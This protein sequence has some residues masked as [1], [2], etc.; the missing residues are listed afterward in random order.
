M[1]KSKTLKFFQFAW[2]VLI[3]IWMASCDDSFS[4]IGSDIVGGVNFDVDTTIV[5]VKATNFNL[6]PI[7]TSNLPSQ[8]LGVYNDPVFGQTRANMVA[9]LVLQQFNPTFGDNPK[10]KNVVLNL[11][12]FS[13]RL[14]VLP[15]GE[16]IYRLD[17]IFGNEPFKL[18]IY[19][20]GFFLN[21]LDPNGNFQSVIPV[22]SDQDQQ[23]FNNRR[24]LLYE[25][26]TV[27]INKNEIVVFPDTGDPAVDT[28][29]S[30]RLPPAIRLE[31]NK[32]FFKRKILDNE[33]K[34]E[35]SNINNFQNFI[36]G[37]YFV[38]EPLSDNKNGMV[39]LDLNQAS[40][41]MN[42][43]FEREVTRTDSLG[44]SVQ[45]ID[46]VDASLAFRFTG[47]KANTLV[48]TE[49]P[50]VIDFVNNPNQ[51]N[52][53]ERLYLQGG[54]GSIA[55]LELFGPDL[56]NDGEPDQL[57]Q[58]KQT[59]KLINE[60]NLVFYI[61]E[62]QV[63]NSIEPVRLVVFDLEKKDFVS[64]FLSDL[65]TTLRDNFRSKTIFGGL[66]EKNQDGRGTRY[67]LRITEHIK[68]I[69]RADSTNTILGVSLTNEVITSGFSRIFNAENN[70]INQAPR[71]SAMNPLGTVLFGNNVSSQN[72]NKKLK[73]EIIFTEP[74]N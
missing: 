6:S 35:L 2:L 12:F 4:E 74:A 57:T 30:Q 50:Q 36:R 32:D 5:D 69:L 67:K 66:I 7:E 70:L 53:D 27:F 34:E 26:D 21:N 61:D 20:N 45:E 28:I 3:F 42:Y 40:V 29:P 44:N 56:D 15:T 19:E 37:L 14:E 65:S 16:S 59:D 1:L 48:K 58:L 10:I 31:L 17:S 60:A 9:Q 13:T 49:N 41:D 51:I 68:N 23:F 24:E 38:V 55:V 11:P 43:T 62:D 72:A 52:G 33:G 47:A 71:F 54:D 18:T 8:L 25:S 39:L 64:D 63:A 46:T 73:L 22:Y